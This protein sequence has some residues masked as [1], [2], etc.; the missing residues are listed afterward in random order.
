MFIIKTTLR[1]SASSLQN[2]SYIYQQ[3]IAS[4]KLLG[5]KS[6]STEILEY[7]ALFS[8]HSGTKIWDALLIKG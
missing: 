2:L 3:K 1:D 8:H 5:K 6:K 7:Y 4:P